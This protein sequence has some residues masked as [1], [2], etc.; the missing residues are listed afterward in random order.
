LSSAAGAILSSDEVNIADI[1]LTWHQ[2]P[3]AS[4]PP[5]Q[6]SSKTTNISGKASSNNC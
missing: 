6:A 4:L 3:L 1:M 2:H 5:D